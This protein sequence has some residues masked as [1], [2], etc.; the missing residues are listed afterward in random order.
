MLEQLQGTREE[1]ATP[2][3]IFSYADAIAKLDSAIEV[4]R[5]RGTAREFAG[6]AVNE[7]QQKLEARE[8]SLKGCFSSLSSCRRAWRS[9][10]PGGWLRA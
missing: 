6:E 8:L 1:T 5:I 7:F 4:I 10:W 9:T 3:V 2:P